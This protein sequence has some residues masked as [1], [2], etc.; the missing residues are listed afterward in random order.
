MTTGG[1]RSNRTLVARVALV[2][3]VTGGAVFVMDHPALEP[4]AFLVASAIG[5]GILIRQA[6]ALGVLGTRKNSTDPD[7]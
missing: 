4:A 1:T 2:L 5:L 7:A 6:A 3:V